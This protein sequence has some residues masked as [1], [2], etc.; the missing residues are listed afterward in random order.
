MPIDFVT[1][2]KNMQVGQC[3][4]LNDEALRHI[5]AMPRITVLELANSPEYALLALKN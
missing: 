5:A 2:A 3:S 1:F 4:A